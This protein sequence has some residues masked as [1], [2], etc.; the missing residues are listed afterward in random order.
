[1]AE[2]LTRGGGLGGLGFGKSVLTLCSSCSPP[3]ARLLR[4]R[5]RHGS[6]HASHRHFVSSKD[7]AGFSEISGV[8]Q[9]PPPLDSAL[10]SK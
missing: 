8:D 5:G 3:S 9:F 7:S 4:E 2:G 1:M 10:I 6:L